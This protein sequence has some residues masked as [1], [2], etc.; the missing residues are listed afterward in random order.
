[1][2]DGTAVHYKTDVFRRI[3]WYSYDKE[4]A[5][6][7]VTLTVDQVKETIAANR[8]GSK[9][10]FAEKV[11]KKEPTLDEIGFKNVVGEESLTRF[12]DKNRNRN[13]NQRRPFRRPENRQDSKPDNRNERPEKRL[14]RPNRPDNKPSGPENKE[15]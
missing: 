10:K 13:N 11:E 9:I 1:M 15:Q 2:P 7:I 8:K 5:N 12:E 6:K 3:M 14:Q 4:N